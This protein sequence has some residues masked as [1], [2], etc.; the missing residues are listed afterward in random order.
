MCGLTSIASSFLTKDEL[1]KFSTS[2]FLN[3]FRG[4]DSTGVAGISKGVLEHGYSVKILKADIPVTKFIALPEY[5]KFMGMPLSSV[6]GHTRAATKGDVNHFNAHPF[7]SQKG[8]ITG[9]HNGT[10]RDKWQFKDPF[11]T[12]FIT[13]L[14]ALIIV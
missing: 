7:V 3:Y 2:L 1:S 6:F 8:F 11:D 14:T 12:V 9:V 4:A 10:L 5:T 13:E